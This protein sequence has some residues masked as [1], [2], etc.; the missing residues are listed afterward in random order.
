MARSIVAGRP[1]LLMRAVAASVCLAAPVLAQDAALR[2]YY[3]ANGLLNRGL[4]EEAAAEYQDFLATE[5]AGAEAAVARYGLAVSLAKLDRPEEALAHL[6]RLDAPR[7]FPFALDAAQLRGQLLYGLGRFADAAATLGALVRAVGDD[8]RA[9]DA[10]GLWVECLHRQGEHREAVQRARALAETFAGEGRDLGRAELYGALSLS[11]IGRDEPAAE[12]LHPLAERQDE[13]G[14]SALLSLAATLVRLGEIERAGLAYE[15]LASADDPRWSV[16]AQLGLAQ[17]RRAQGRSAAAIPLLEELLR[18]YPEAPSA[19]DARLELG[20]NLIETGEHEQGRKV[21][22]ELSRGDDLGLADHAR[23]WLARSSLQTGD[24]SGAAA[25][26]AEALESMPD[27]TIRAEMLYDLGIARSEAGETEA[28]VDAFDRVVREHPGHRL[29]QTA[30]LAAATTLLR[31]GRHGEAQA[32]AE[33]VDRDA[34]E[35]AEAELVIAEAEAV[36]GRHD[37][38]IE[39]LREWLAAHHHHP[40][41]TRA[42]FR[43][44]MSLAAEGDLGGAEEAGAAVF[45]ADPVEPRFRTGLIAMGD[46]A[47]A[48]SAWPRAETWYRRAVEQGAE[49]R[50]AAHLKLGLALARQGR[51]D[52]A[53]EWFTRANAFPAEQDTS[54]QILFE[55]AQAHLFRGDDRS[56]AETLA[57]LL[58][59][60]ADSRFAPHAMQHLGGVAERA[61]DPE[62][63]ARWYRRAAQS[64]DEPL[65]AAA[66]R[67]LARASLAAGDLDAVQQLSVES[68]DPDLRAYAGIA[69]ARA[70]DTER[71]VEQIDAALRSD[72]LSREVRR[73]AQLERAWCVRR[74][75]ERAEAL[76]T[77]EEIYAEDRTDRF[78]VFAALE[79]ASLELEGDRAAEAREWIGRARDHMESDPALAGPAMRAQLDYTTARAAASRDDH[80][81]VVDLLEHFRDSYPGSV[82]TPA[83]DILLG[84]ALIAL[85]RPRLGAVAFERAL[86]E[87]DPELRAAAMLRLGD[88][89]G[90]AG[91]W[92]RSRQVFA[93][94]LASHGD[95]PHAY[96]ARFGLGW[97]LEQSGDLDA[98]VESYREVIAEHN[99]PTAARAQFQIGECLFAQERYD[100]AVRELLRVDILYD[101]PQWSAAALYEAGRAFEQLRKLGEARRQYRETLERFA[102]SEWAALAQ[103]RLERL[104]EAGRE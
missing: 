46:A 80:Q 73:A 99:G 34:P 23:Y 17:V 4:F 61:G 58:D 22:A 35:R 69:S 88:A 41:S 72:G 8:P 85:D 82:L 43:L 96:Q 75:G 76:R 16:P 14:R 48:Q 28:A 15:R 44:A 102:D 60:A 40:A 33:R 98:A 36:L 74:S 93:D 9:A 12:I 26:L 32:R 81:T 101:Y 65:R 51:H 59:Q 49:P 78:A 47:F 38:T 37:D 83:A 50:A 87:P 92:E 97:A 19:V 71:A 79:A 64:G 3:T 7:D 55:S 90:L 6:D 91:D 53:I 103:E 29:A 13:I 67:D 52:E 18:L 86:E 100:E 39:R 62:A 10:G 56:A 27:S 54:A 42:H 11:A 1:G 89:L 68:R 5:P 66:L 63:A 94:Y 25:A 24:A 70:G 95:A 2:T 45:D 30:T 57:R 31:A 77:L 21:L 84:D 20:I 104:S